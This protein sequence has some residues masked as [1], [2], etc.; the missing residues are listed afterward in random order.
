MED[1]KY[2]APIDPTDK[3]SCVLAALKNEIAQI[4][5]REVFSE[6]VQE[7]ENY[8]GEFGKS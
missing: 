3:V 5:E 6:L 2:E 4:E 1:M 8:I 7:I